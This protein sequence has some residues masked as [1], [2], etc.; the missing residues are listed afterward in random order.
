VVYR[1]SNEYRSQRNNAIAPEGTCQVTAAIMALEATGIGFEYPKD[2]Q[3]EDHLATLLD[4]PEA[5]AKL[6]K[7]YPGLSGRPP[8]EVHRILSWAINE[9][10]V[11]ANVT[12]F[13]TRA[14][15]AELLFRI[16]RHRAASLV[17][18]RF[19]PDGHIIALVGFE[20][21]QIDLEDAP[22]PAAIDLSLIRQVIVDDPWGDWTSAYTRLEGDDVHLP[23]SDFDRLTREYGESGR[24]WAH[25]FSRDG[26]F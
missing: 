7:E 15:I 24:K 4:S 10:L 18:G 11:R 20:S 16:A 3:P 19:T 9:L 5:E 14:S 8:R 6:R 26:K 22:S 1:L 21:E 12:T 23:L 25:L 13:T 2:V 17:S